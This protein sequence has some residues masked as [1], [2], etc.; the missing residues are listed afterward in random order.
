MEEME[1]EKIEMEKIEM[2]EME[3][4]EIEIEEIK[5]EEME[6]PLSF[7]G[8]GGVVGLTRWFEK[9]EMMFYI[10]NCPKKY[11]VKNEVLKMEIE[12]W[13]LAVKGIDLTAYTRR[14][15]EWV[16]L[17]TRMVPNEEDK[18]ERFVRGLPDNI[19][20]NLIAAEPIKLQDAIR[21]ANNLM[22]QKLKGYARSAKNKRRSKLKYKFQDQENSE[23]IFSFGSALEDFIYVVFVF[24]R[25]INTFFGLGYPHRQ[26]SH[27]YL[28]GQES[29]YD[30]H[31][32]VSGRRLATSQGVAQDRW[33]LGQ[34]IELVNI[35][36]D[37]RALMLTRTMAK[38]LSVT[39]AHECLFVD[40]L[41]EEEPKKV[42]EALK[43][44]G[45]VDAMQDELNQF[46][47]NKVWTLIPESYEK[48]IIRS[49]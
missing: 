1:I 23:D 48:T 40:F 31:S 21:I 2:K 45:W 35:I 41:S 18:V 17:C 10:S 42:S 15:K 33:S 7:N 8:T 3:M 46:A 14:F 20:R 29:E 5:M 32:S 12:L 44:Q 36:D 9:M 37:P 22:D 28:Q 27:R 24:D 25:N 19:W 47:R 13:N 38:T 6:M 34:H 4:K 30:W 43:H 11:Q 26:T 49:K 39:S 16:L